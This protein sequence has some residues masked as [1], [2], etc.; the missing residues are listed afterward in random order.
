MRNFRRLVLGL[1]LVSLVT[2]LKA[3]TVMYCVAEL[4]T[5]LVREQGTWK[6]TSF[7]R[8][9][10]TVKFDDGFNRL[11]GVGPS[12]TFACARPYGKLDYVTCSAQWNNGEIFV[13]NLETG[14]FFYNTANIHGY[15]SDIPE[16]D[17][18]ALYA[19]TCTKF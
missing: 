12:D 16:P 5:G 2:P 1:V 13:L 3:E 8:I 10:W 4:A 6:E 11:E 19:G 9:R 14:R 17:T 18:D 7:N 15:V